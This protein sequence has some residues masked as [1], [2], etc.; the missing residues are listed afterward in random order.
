MFRSVPSLGIEAIYEQSVR[1]QLQTTSSTH[2]KPY[3]LHI[4][5]ILIRLYANAF[6]CMLQG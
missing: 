2:Y 3:M 6:Y 4:V 1:D 5:A